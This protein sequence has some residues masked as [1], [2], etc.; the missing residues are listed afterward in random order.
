MPI[1]HCR[2]FA[3]RIPTMKARQNRTPMDLTTPG[4]ALR[5]RG[6]ELLS[7]AG[8]GAFTVTAAMAFFAPLL[9]P[10][11]GVALHCW[12]VLLVAGQGAD[13]P[14]ALAA[15]FLPVVA[16]LTLGARYWDTAGVLHPYCVGLLLYGGLW[17][18]RWLSVAL[19]IRADPCQEVPEE[20][21]VRLA[22]IPG[23]T[24]TGIPAAEALA[25][26]AISDPPTA[27]LPR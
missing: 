8:D 19:L 2:A 25:P 23:Q 17:G 1:S 11:L 9:L 15:V 26:S 20:Q 3:I 12:T 16:E 6:E 21:S 22:G 7:R 5:L 24:T 10:P 27:F 4:A 18:A 14:T 13:L